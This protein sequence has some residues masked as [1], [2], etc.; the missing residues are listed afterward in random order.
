MLALYCTSSRTL[1]VWWLTTTLLEPV[2]YCFLRS[3]NRQGLQ[4]MILPLGLINQVKMAVWFSNIVVEQ[5]SLFCVKGQLLNKLACNS[6]C[7]S[8]KNSNRSRKLP[9]WRLT[10][11]SCGLVRMRGLA[12]TCRCMPAHD[13]TYILAW[14]CVDN[15]ISSWYIYLDQNRIPRNDKLSHSVF[16][17]CIMYQHL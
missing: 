14:T 5:E 1:S 2:G 11:W 7:R 15:I 8:C 13:N 9:F 4:K 16:L 6:S 17:C 12:C 10:N 3:L